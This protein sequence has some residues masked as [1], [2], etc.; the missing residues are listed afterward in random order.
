[1]ERARRVGLSSF[2]NTFDKLKKV[3]NR[4]ISK[5]YGLSKIAGV[6][7]DDVNKCEKTIPIDFSIA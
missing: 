4:K 1:M 7:Q 5:T 2:L 6:A 3:V